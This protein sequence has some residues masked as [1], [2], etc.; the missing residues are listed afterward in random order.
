M[1]TDAAG[2]AR[3][4]SD[5]RE[6]EKVGRTAVTC[7]VPAAGCLCVCAQEV[8]LHTQ[9]DCRPIERIVLRLRA[10]SRVTD[11]AQIKL[12]ARARAMNSSLAIGP[13]PDGCVYRLCPSWRARDATLAQLQVCV[14][15]AH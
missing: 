2:V 15:C 11:Q 4:A 9:Y 10:R 13:E 3:R 14:S 12:G 1:Y 6:S 8:Y 5:A 7:C